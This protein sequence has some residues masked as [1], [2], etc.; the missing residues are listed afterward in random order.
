MQ[1]GKG[2]CPGERRIAESKR[3][4]LAPCVAIRL[5]ASGYPLV[6]F[7]A[8][9]ER[10]LNARSF[11]AVQAGYLG[12]FFCYCNLNGA[13]LNQ[14]QLNG[15]NFGL[16]GTVLGLGGETGKDDQEEGDYSFHVLR[17]YL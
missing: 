15:N 8:E 4:T 13:Y 1:G 17:C 5:L 6:V 9:V 10:L 12:I 11:T 2:R 16:G 7:G 3:R 14:F